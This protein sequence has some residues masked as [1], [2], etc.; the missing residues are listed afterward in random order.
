VAIEKNLVSECRLGVLQGLS[1]PGKR[2]PGQKM[3]TFWADAELL[4]A[5]EMA[6]KIPPRCDRSQFIRDAIIDKLRKLRY[7]VDP[8]LSQPPDRA[9]KIIQISRHKRPM[10]AEEA[11]APYGS[12]RKK[13]A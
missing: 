13:K 6:R 8:E 7:P 1:M 5:V 9:S 2:A 4:R 10:A 12:K 11:A 3:I